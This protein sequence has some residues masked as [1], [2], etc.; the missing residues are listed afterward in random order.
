MSDNDFELSRRE[1]VAG[2]WTTGV[3]STS[4]GVRTS[5]NFSDE[6]AITD[7]TVQ[8]GELDLVVDYETSVNQGGVDTGSVTGGSDLSDGSAVIDGITA[9]REYVM[10]DVKP[11]DSGQITFCPKIIDNPGWLWIGSDNG[12][13]GFEN[14]QTE[15]EAAVDDTAGGPDNGKSQGELA[16]AIRASASYV[17]AQT[18]GSTRAMGDLGNSTLSGLFQELESGLLLEGEP[19]P[20]DPDESQPYPGS[21]DPNTQTGPCLRLEW[22]VPTSVGNEIQTDVIKFSIKFVTIQARHNPAP[23]NPFTDVTTESSDEGSGVDGTTEN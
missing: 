6:E 10:R 9:S 1:L 3:L 16:E 5:A 12:L 2:L 17:D 11:G 22:A 20:G 14:G 8:S 21:S 23:G 18:P 15:P 19:F 13:T 7:N 4:A